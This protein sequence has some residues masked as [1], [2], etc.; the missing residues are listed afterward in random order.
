MRETHTDQRIVRFAFICVNPSHPCSKRFGFVSALDPRWRFG[1]VWFV[2]RAYFFAAGSLSVSSLRTFFTPGSSLT[3]FSASRLCEGV[4]TF[5][6]STTTPSA[7]S[8]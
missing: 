8:S 7:S 6:R 4:S 2:E 5:P 1:L 3:T